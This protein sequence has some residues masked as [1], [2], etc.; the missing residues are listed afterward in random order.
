MAGLGPNPPG[1]KLTGS[2]TQHYSRDVL[3]R[4]VNKLETL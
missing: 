1:Q 2:A 3:E 4:N